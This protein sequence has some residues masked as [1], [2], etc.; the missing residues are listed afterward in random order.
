MIARALLLA[1]L[2]LGLTACGGRYQLGSATE[3]GFTTLHVA[4]VRSEAMVPQATALVTTALREAFIKDGRVRLVDD[5]GQA[6]A[7]LRV[8]LVTFGREMT[9]AQTSDTGLS[10]RHDLTLGA[11]ATLTDRRDGRLL[12]DERPLS[13]R[14]GVFSDDGH[15]PAEY[16]TLPLLAERLADDTVRAV[17]ERW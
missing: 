5:P 13:A 6:D 12:L 4:V 10:R 2:L 15:G 14:R 11:R 9:V 3:P 16:Q 17:L 8:T 1:C 7:I